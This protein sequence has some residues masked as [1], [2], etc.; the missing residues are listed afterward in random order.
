[1]LIHP[2]VKY[3]ML[4]KQQKIDLNI[5]IGWHD[6]DCIRFIL[7]WNDNDEMGVDGQADTGECVEVPTAI[8]GQLL[9]R[10]YA[11][12]QE[13]SDDTWVAKKTEHERVKALR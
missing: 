13:A 5:K 7:T 1:M 6:T 4:S 3:R 9:R 2:T 11:T 8:A 10:G 12:K